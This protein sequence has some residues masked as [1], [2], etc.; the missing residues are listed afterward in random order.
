MRAMD[1]GSVPPVQWQIRTTMLTNSSDRSIESYFNY[2]LV[3]K[4]MLVL[5]LSW[6]D[7]E[8]CDL[9]VNAETHRLVA[10]RLRVSQL[11]DY[12]LAQICVNVKHFVWFCWYFTKKWRNLFGFYQEIDFFPHFSS[13]SLHL[14]KHL[15]PKNPLW[16]DSGDGWA[17][18]SIRCLLVSMSGFLLRASLPQ[19]IKTKWSEF[20]LRYLMMF[21][22][23]IS[24]PWPRWLPALWASTVRVLLSSNTPCF[25][26]RVRSPELGMGAPVSALISLKILRSD[27][28]IAMSEWTEKARPFAWPGPW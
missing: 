4:L 7:I 22:V 13:C 2:I 6:N 16:A 15:L 24:Q 5:N 10:V 11:Y 23:N 18:S 20:A 27:G 14:L 19:S 9:P 25:A 17:D 28:G 3:K 12:I 26:Q 8:I 1:F 21:S